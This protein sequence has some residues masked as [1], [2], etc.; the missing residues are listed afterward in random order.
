MISRKI[1]SLFGFQRASRSRRLRFSPLALEELSERIVPASTISG[2]V[3]MGVDAIDPLSATNPETP[4]QGISVLLDGANPVVTDANGAYSFANVTA[5]SHKV[6]VQL[7]AGS[8]LWGFTAQTLQGYTLSLADGQNYSQLNFTLT[9]QNSALVQ[10]FYQQLLVR[11]SDLSGLNF[12]VGSLAAD[13][14]G[15]AVLNTFLTSQEYAVAVAPMANL[16]AGFF[17]NAPVDPSLLRNNIQ[18]E[19]QGVTPDALAL[20]ILYSEPFVAAF[21]DTSQLGNPQ[22]VTF[23]YQNLLHRTPDLAGLNFWTNMLVGGANRGEAVLGFESSPEFLPANPGLPNQVTVS[24]VYEGILGREADPSGFAFWTSQTGITATS[25]ANTFLGSAEYSGLQGYN[26]LMLADIAAQPYKPEVSVLSRLQQFDPATGLFDLP[27]TTGSITGLTAAGKPANLYVVAHGWEPG[28][29]EDVLLNSTPGN[30]LKTWQTVQLPG[31]NP[32]AP[33]SAFL[34]QGLNQVST[35]GLGQAIYDDD[36]NAVVVAYSWLDDSATPLAANPSTADLTALS[37]LLLAGQSESNAQ[38]N[39]VRMASA[40]EQALGTSFFQNQGL[41]HLMGHSHGAKVATVAALTLQQASVP[42]TQLTLLES[43]EDGPDIQ[44]PLPALGYLHAAGLGSAQN[45]LWYYLSQMQLSADPLGGTTRTPTNKTFVDS[46]YSSYGFGAPLGGFLAA[47]QTGLVDVNLHPEILYG[48]PTTSQIIQE[49]EKALAELANTLIQSHSYP[50]F[51]YGQS[52]LLTSFALQ[53]SPLLNPAIAPALSKIYMQ[54]WAPT[55]PATSPVFSQQYNLTTNGITEPTY[56]PT[57]SPLQFAQQYQVGQVAIGDAPSQNQSQTITLGGDASA[58]DVAGL[59]FTPNS[60]IFTN[61]TD[62]GKAGNGLDFQFQFIN[63]Q[64]G[65][66]LVVWTR[67]MTGVSVPLASKT[68]GNLG[69]QSLQLFD[70][71]GTTAGT[72]AQTATI[73]LDSFSNATFVTG[74]FNATKVPLFGFT[75]I[76]GPNSTSSV[77]ITNLQQLNDGTV[78]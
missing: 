5:G 33:A 16:L 35:T 73:S 77:Q 55:P 2:N 18:L 49:P 57:F 42:V 64:P 70:M 20:N 36:P 68:T 3:F 48:L 51:W 14:T 23:L 60:A 67:G 66:R 52:S 25:L 6:S 11:S 50:P 47:T 40:V 74:G 72:T 63:P 69:Y 62:L 9:P 31:G 24:M 53:W 76:H 29:T 1:A 34:F 39:G 45:F 78:T 7:A 26:D 28:F 22:F 12:W 43:P 54:N 44:A 71:L 17:P 56:T 4:L 38:M 13:N 59:S 10:N 27:V 41:I 30:P 15:G 46:Y 19:R 58:M 65:D 21:G 8:G 61:D 75:L 37:S 32:P